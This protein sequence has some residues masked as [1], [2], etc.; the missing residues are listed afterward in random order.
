MAVGIEITMRNM[1]LALLIK[2]RLFPDADE[3][4]NGVL[5][6]ILFYAAAAMGA[7]LPL[8]LRYRRKARKK[9]VFCRRIRACRSIAAKSWIVAC[10][11]FPISIGIAPARRCVSPS[12]R[13]RTVMA[14]KIIVLAG[15]DEGRVFVLG[16]E[17]M[18]FGRSRATESYLTDP[19]VSR[20]HCQVIPEGDQYV[21]VD[22]DSAS[23]TF[24]NGKEIER[25]ILQ[26]GDLIRI[27][28]THMQYVVEADAKHAAPK[29]AASSPSEWAK[30][31]VAQTIS[32]YYI[33]APL[34]RGR[35]SY[36][37]HARDTNNDTPVVLKVLHPDFG[38]DDQ[39]VQA[40]FVEA[41]KTTMPLSHTHLLKIYGAGKTGKYCWVA[42]EYI[43]GDSLAAVI[44]RSEKAGKLDWK[45]VAR[46]GIVIAS[47]AQ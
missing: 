6:V 14:K 1:N 5:F 41:M 16:T 31:L 17:T 11:I 34:A 10:R 37:F 15:P 9:P 43:P 22:F 30:A 28:G 39:K 19:H 45:A 12:V 42:T 32:H 13:H 44:A 21:V 27:G 46:V 7:G 40:A 25:H 24:V 36:S 18:M 4:G 29:P 2:A 20:V 47:A 8:A 38:E 26:S 3:L 23:G 33:S 35:N